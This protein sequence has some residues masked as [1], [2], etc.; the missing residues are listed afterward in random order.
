MERI[1]AK[2]FLILLIVSKLFLLYSVDEN[3]FIKP[4]LINGKFF[5][6]KDLYCFF[7]STNEK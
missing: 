7:I 5:T 2:F 3:F 1:H 4:S 6:V